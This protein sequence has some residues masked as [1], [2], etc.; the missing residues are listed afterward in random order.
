MWLSKRPG[1]ER[2]EDYTGPGVVSV[3]GDG[4]GVINDMERRN[5]R[6]FAPGGYCWRPAA[7]DRVLVI[8]GDEPSIA[9]LEQ[10]APEDLAPGEVLLYSREAS[11]CLKNDGRI[12]LTGRVYLNGKAYQEHDDS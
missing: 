10:A 9:G 11:I 7:E 6:V 12:L 4:L 8:K 2:R 5:A 1:Q 3:A